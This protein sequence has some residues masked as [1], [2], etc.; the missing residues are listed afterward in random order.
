MKKWLHKRFVERKGQ[1]IAS[2]LL[3][4]AEIIVLRAISGASALAKS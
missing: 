4:T 2:G 1:W 3:I